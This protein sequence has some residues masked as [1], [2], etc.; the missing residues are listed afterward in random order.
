MDY[1]VIVIGAGIH[2]AGVAQA[3]AAAGYRTLVLEQYGQAAHGSSSRSSKLIHGGLRYLESAQFRLVRECLRERSLLLQNA[4]HLVRLVPFHIP[5]YRTTQRRP[6]KI[7]LGLYLYSLLGDN[8]FQTVPRAEW[9]QLDDL[10]TDGLQTVF[11]YQDA[12]TDDARLTRAVLSSA[13]SLGAE[14]RYNCQFAYA[15]CQG[16]GC[17]VQYL[18]NETANQVQ[19]R[20]VVNATGPWANRSL[21]LFEGGPRPVTVEL[22]QGTHLLVPGKPARGMYYLEAP[23]DQRAVFVMPWKTHTLL[24]T[25]ET[26]FSGDP[27]SVR[28]LEQEIDYLLQVYAWYFRQRIERDAV[29]GS[30]AGLR[31]LPAGRSDAFNRSRDTLLYLDRERCPAVLT[32]YGGKLT[33]YRATAERVLRYLQPLLPTATRNTNTATLRLPEVD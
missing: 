27:A 1:D 21:K 31:V 7:R 28:P 18:N 32:I 14:V 9:G 17:T 11:R 6:W 4:P 13:H 19:T 12:Q 25:T 26:R 8:G 33:S 24:G 20:A 23:Q 22:I 3:A 16:P 10:R 15:R 2:G 29:L 5:V 30:F